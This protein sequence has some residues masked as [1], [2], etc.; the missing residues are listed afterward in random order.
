[1]FSIRVFCNIHSKTGICL[2]AYA[3]IITGATRLL[4]VLAELLLQIFA[5]HDLFMVIIEKYSNATK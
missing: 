5:L 3:V 2:Q 4:L 1:M